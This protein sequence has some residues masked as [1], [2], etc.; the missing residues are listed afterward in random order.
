MN[1]MLFIF[2][3]SKPLPSTFEKICDI[4]D[5]AIR[6]IATLS[7]PT[8]WDTSPVFSGLSLDVQMYCR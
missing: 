6:S 4:A 7:S 8:G 3:K 1:I 5:G 2:Q